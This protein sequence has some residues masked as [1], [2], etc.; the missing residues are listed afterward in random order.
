MSDQTF[1]DALESNFI[2]YVEENTYAVGPK[3]VQE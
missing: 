1:D 3:M 2:I